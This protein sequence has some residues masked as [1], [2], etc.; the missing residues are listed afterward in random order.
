MLYKSVLTRAHEREF[1]LDSGPNNRPIWQVA[2][3]REANKARNRENPPISTEVTD[4][5][6]AVDKWYARVPFLVIVSCSHSLSVSLFSLHFS[7][8]LFVFLFCVTSPHFLFLFPLP[9]CIS[10]FVPFHSLPHL[11]K[12]N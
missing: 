8:H 9:I 1:G 3:E 10:Q 6:R 7:L 2:E 12:Q 5:H 11:I 4:W